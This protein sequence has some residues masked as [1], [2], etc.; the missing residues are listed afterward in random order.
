MTQVSITG[1][2]RKPSTDALLVVFHWAAVGA[3]LVSILTG[4]RI[5]ADTPDAALARWLASIALE[6]DVY[7][8]HYLAGVT[9][10]A[11]ALG[12]A[13]YLVRARLAGR[14][15]I[16]AA[17]TRA[18]LSRGG[19]QAWRVRN[20]WVYYVLFGL[21]GLLAASGITLYLDLKP[22][23]GVAWL[24]TLHLLA[25]YSLIGAAVLHVAAQY[26]FGAAVPKATLARAKYGLL[27]LLKMLRPRFSR[28]AQV[29]GVTVQTNPA[30]M[31]TAVAAALAVGGGLVAADRSTEDTLAIGRIHAGSTP[32]LDGH[33][34]DPAWAAA[35]T[36]RIHTREG[37][38][39]PGGESLVEVQAVH[40]GAN[41]YL[42][43]RWEDPTRSLKHLPLVKTTS[44]WKLVHEQYDIED[45][46][47]YYEDKLGVLL[48]RS[49][50]PGGGGTVH[51]GPQPL[52]GKPPAFS[53]RGL[54]YTADGSVADMW[55]WKAVR[56]GFLGELGWADDDQFG[57]PA[58]AKPKEAAGEERYKAGY[59]T[60][61]G[62]ASYANNF[63]HEGPG[64]YA[65]LIKPLRLPLNWRA[66]QARLGTD[67]DP[68][69]S[70]PLPWSMSQAES[71]DYS[72]ELDAAIPVGTAIPGVL[73]G[74]AGLE[75]DRGDVRCAADWAEAHW[76]LECRRALD[77]GSAH[78]V[79]LRPGE[80]VH[81]WVSVFDRTQTRHSRHMRPIVL[82]LED[83][84]AA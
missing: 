37:T 39:L 7:R 8:L 73:L 77:T 64:G 6:G 46:D 52:P 76:T 58:E 24:L 5:A 19:R 2:P 20:L 80:P 35:E 25:A 71:V 49:P 31:V 21:I 47:L 30:A 67:L 28:G 18:M 62:K 57:P 41:V 12:Y 51:L 29:P 14:F 4:L 59:V 15:L 84:P 48:S 32:V 63:A 81:L 9:I 1:S 68:G 16:P 55:Q 53:G 72:P 45:E 13:I 10:T 74:A 3:L 23:F 26:A 82:W 44:G 69:H 36:V 79:A 78:D 65:G 33:G 11:T 54:H 50:E 60:D 66:L 70:D 56:T 61:P 38:N 43:F 42:K 75:G 34:S 83:V 22:P 27:W 17:K 40:D